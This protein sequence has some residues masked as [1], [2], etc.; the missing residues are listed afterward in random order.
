[1]SAFSFVVNSAQLSPL[2]GR[3]IL[4]LL[5]VSSAGPWCSAGKRITRHPSSTEAP[6]TEV[7]DVQVFN[8]PFD[9]I[10]K[11]DQLTFHGNVRTEDDRVAHWFVY[12]CPAWW[13][14]CQFLSPAYAQMGS[15]WQARLNGALFSSE[16]RFAEVDCAADKVLCNDQGVETYPTVMHYQGG[17]PVGKWE[18]TLRRGD[19]MEVFKRALS[20]WLVKQLAGAVA[21]VAEAPKT[22]ANGVDGTWA[23]FVSYLVPSEIAKDILVIFAV[24]AMLFRVIMNNPELWGKAPALLQRNQVS[25]IACDRD[26]Q[27]NIADFTKVEN[28]VDPPK[29]SNKV[30]EPKSDHIGRFFPAEWACNLPSVDL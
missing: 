18:G 19:S 3:C 5:I 8:D 4:L 30:D 29:A 20:K 1:M 16:V 2:A 28:I 15:E 9:T 6:Q 27:C 21:K 17:K 12:Y 11:L 25:V 22:M 24:I 14:P 26:S 13:E 10:L 7:A 23:N